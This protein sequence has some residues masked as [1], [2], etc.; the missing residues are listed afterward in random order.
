MSH[1]TSKL[2]DRIQITTAE[3]KKII[4]KAQMVESEPQP[5][6]VKKLDCS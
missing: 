3:K 2:L 1:D 5:A 4:C 6:F